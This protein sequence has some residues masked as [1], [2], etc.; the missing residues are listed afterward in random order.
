MKKY[1]IYFENSSGERRII[2]EIE[3]PEEVF[4]TINKFLDEHKFK[5]YY[6]RITDG[7]TEYCLDVGSHT[8]FFYVSK[9][10][11]KLI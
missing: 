2:A 7:D 1:P 5:S 4:K 9:E 10:I 8:E 3:T 6:C 11:G